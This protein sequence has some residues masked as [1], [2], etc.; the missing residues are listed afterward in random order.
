M[1]DRCERPESQS[2]AYYGGRGITICRRWRESFEAFLSDMGPRPSP[3]HEID[4]K[5]GD[6]DYEPSNCRWATAI[7][8][9][10]NRKCV[11]MLTHNGETMPIAAWTRRLGMG[12][13]TLYNRLRRGWTVERA[14]SE[15]VAVSPARA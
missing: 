14:L 13:F 12:E 7:E 6:G 15:I 9:N 10:W 2:F 8:Q 11:R 3:T 5:D 4:R 1:I